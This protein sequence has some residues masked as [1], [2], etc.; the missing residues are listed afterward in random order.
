[1]VTVY[2]IFLQSGGAG[3][4]AAEAMQTPTNV[5]ALHEHG[6]MTVVIDGRELDFSRQQFQLQDDAFHFESGNG[7]VWHTHAQGVTLEYALSTL[8]IEANSSAVTYDGTT[9]RASD[10]GT[11]VTVAVNGQPVDPRDYVLDGTTDAASAGQGDSVRVV[12]RT[13]GGNT[14]S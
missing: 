6:S 5:G 2:V 14:T 12:V 13:D 3:T 8:G 1:V 11:T 4:A 10:P 7:E 9:Y